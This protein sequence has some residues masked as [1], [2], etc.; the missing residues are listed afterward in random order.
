MFRENLS[1]RGMDLFHRGA[2]DRIDMGTVLSRIDALREWRAFLPTLKR[3][4]SLTDEEA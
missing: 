2:T 4:V 1:K 3:L